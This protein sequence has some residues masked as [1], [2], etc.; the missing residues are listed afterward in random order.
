V[1][2][3]ARRRCRAVLISELKLTEETDATGAF[4]F[5]KFPLGNQVVLSL[6][7]ETDV[8]GRGGPGR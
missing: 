2:T 8:A 5:S 3:R 1:S 7:N 6:G 4:T